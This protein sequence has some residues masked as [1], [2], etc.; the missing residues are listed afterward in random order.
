M[1]GLELFDET[2]NTEHA[3]TLMNQDFRHAGQTD[4][5]TIFQA[6]YT[7]K[8]PELECLH[9]LLADQLVGES[10]ETPW[11]SAPVM[12][13]YVSLAEREDGVPVRMDDAICIMENRQKLYLVRMIFRQPTLLPWSEDADLS[14]TIYRAET[15]DGVH[16]GFY[17]Q[18]ANE[19]HDAM[20]SSLYWHG[21]MDIEDDAI[22]ENHQITVEALQTVVRDLIDEFNQQ[23]PD[24]L[25]A[26][27]EQ[28]GM[29]DDDFE[30]DSEEISD[31]ASSDN[32]PIIH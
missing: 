2:P 7:L 16:Q 25:V 32:I 18:V 1:Q 5:L 31:E 20:A 14:I 15:Q 3:V 28:V 30:E 24:G 13:A 6:E 17:D 8:S 29:F 9:C 26:N 27:L 11:L 22:R 10:D 19:A 21:Q 4:D 23:M 12:A